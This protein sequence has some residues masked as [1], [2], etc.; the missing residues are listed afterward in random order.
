MPE[1]QPSTSGRA[2]STPLQLVEFELSAQRPALEPILG[3][4]RDRE[5]YQMLQE[6][7]LTANN[8]LTSLRSLLVFLRRGE[9]HENR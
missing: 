9:K 6:L 2:F 3:Q 4:F 1:D 7:M 5:R 8:K